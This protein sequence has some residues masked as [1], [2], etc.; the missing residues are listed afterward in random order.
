MDTYL[1]PTYS[2]I[3]ILIL[4]PK[5]VRP[6]YPLH[7]D[8]QQRHPPQFT[9]NVKYTCLIVVLNTR[10]ISISLRILSGNFF[11]FLLREEKSW[12]IRLH[13]NVSSVCVFVCVCSTITYKRLEQTLCEQT[14]LFQ[15]LKSRSHSWEVVRE[16]ECVAGVNVAVS[17]YLAI[18]SRQDN[19]NECVYK[20]NVVSW[21]GAWH[22]GWCW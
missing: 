7:E 5:G 15:K 9:K 2:M 1:R 12:I 16:T 21:P 4:F 22:G 20:T 11:V 17:Y 18:F 14:G 19:W 10:N 8:S 6:I 3:Y 13:S